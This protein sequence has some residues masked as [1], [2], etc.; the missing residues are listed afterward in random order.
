MRDDTGKAL[1]ELEAIAELASAN[2]PRSTDIQVA[3][4]SPSKTQA[5][6]T[7]PW[8]VLREIIKLSRAALEMEGRDG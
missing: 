1:R 4:A 2:F 8:Y 6:T 3:V 7:I 5:S